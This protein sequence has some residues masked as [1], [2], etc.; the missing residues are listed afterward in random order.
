[1]GTH[2][3]KSD[4][5]HLL[6]HRCAEP[7]LH[8]WH[9]RLCGVWCPGTAC[10]VAPTVSAVDISRTS[11]FA[12]NPFK[13][14]HPCAWVCHPS[15]TN[16]HGPPKS[17]CSQSSFV[18]THPTAFRSET[19]LYIF[20]S[21]RGFSFSQKLIFPKNCKESSRWP[22]QARFSIAVIADCLVQKRSACTN[23]PPPGCPATVP[24]GPVPAVVL[25]CP[26]RVTGCD[27]A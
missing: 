22:L 17:F 10:G 4:S 14:P 13:S 7:Q 20:C 6:D 9:H 26:P 8:D 19:H 12:A 25:E 15:T 11:V 21:M 3:C 16:E 24:L 23:P 1:M 18:A 27:R 5:S 2:N